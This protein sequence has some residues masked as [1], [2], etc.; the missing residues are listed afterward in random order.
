MFKRIILAAA[1]LTVTAAGALLPSGAQAHWRH[2]C[3]GYGYG[4][5]YLGGPPIV[6]S[7]YYPARYYYGPRVYRG[8]Y[9]GPFYR[10]AY[11]SPYVGPYYGSGV[12]VSF[13]W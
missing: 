10:R 11:Y 2:G 7:S 6:Y 9:G 1:L 13:G 12:N 8:Y 3:Y 4:G 5:P